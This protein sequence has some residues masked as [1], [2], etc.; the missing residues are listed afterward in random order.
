MSNDKLMQ[1]VNT[2]FCQAVMLEPWNAEPGRL[3]VDYRARHGHTALI[4]NGVVE[5][6]RTI[7]GPILLAPEGIMGGVYDTGMLLA[8]ER[9]VEAPIDQG[10]P[11]LTI[12]INVAA[13]T[14]PRDWKA[15]LVQA[16]QRPAAGVQFQLW[17]Y[18]LRRIEVG[19]IVVEVL[20]CSTNGEPVATII[21]TNAGLL[22]QQLGRLVDTDD[23]PVTVAV[24]TGNRLPRVADG[25]LH[26][27][28][29]VAEAKL[30]AIA[31]GL[32]RLFRE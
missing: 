1:V 31:A 28:D 8:D 3:F 15:V 30:L 24:A 22:P 7:S 23:A 12:G 16:M 17:D 10:W 27:A 19:D 9:D 32:R 26:V 29:V 13:P 4:G 5:E 2:S 11:P 14:M 6:F 25:E 18:R 20:Q 21:V